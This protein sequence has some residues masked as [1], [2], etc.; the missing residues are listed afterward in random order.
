MRFSLRWMRSSCGSLL[1]TFVV[2]LSRPL[3]VLTHPKK[4]LYFFYIFPFYSTPKM[5]RV[6]FSVGSERLRTYLEPVYFLD[7]Q[8]TFDS[9]FGTDLTMLRI[10]RRVVGTCAIKDT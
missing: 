4:S 8:Q 10:S 1:S 3:S 9:I 6:Q 5:D 2:I 7:H